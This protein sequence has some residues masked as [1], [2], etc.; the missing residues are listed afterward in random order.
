[1]TDQSTPRREAPSF[2]AES[3]IQ[4]VASSIPGMVSYWDANL[5]CQYAN[6]AYQAWFGK[7]P[8]KIHGIKLQDLQGAELFAKNKPHILQALAGKEQSFERDLIRPNGEVGWFWV[9]YVPHRINDKVVGFAALIFNI[10]ERKLAQEALKASE[11]RRKVATDSGRVAIWEVD[12]KTNRLIWDDNCFLL[13]Q[14]DKEEF[15]GTFEQWAG[16]IHTEDLD[17]VV[18]SFQKTVLGVGKYNPTFR[19]SWPDGTFRHIEAHGEV[20]K[21]KDG[22]PDRFIGTNWDVTDRKRS[23]EAIRLSEASESANLA[24]SIFLANMS[25]ELRTPLAGIMGMVDLALG[26]AM[27]SKQIDWLNKSKQSAL[28]LMSVINDILDI[29]KIEAGNLTLEERNFSVSNV[30]G[31][32]IQ[33]VEDMARGKRLAL[34]LEM[35]PAAPDLLCGDAL[36]LKQIALNY[37]SNAVKF[38]E[39]G[40]VTLRTQLVEQNE[41]S[42]MLRIDVI[43]QGM[44]VSAELQDR[45]FQSFTQ[46]DNSTTRKF[47]GTGLGL[48]ISR[49]IAR[50][51]GGDTG[52]ISHQGQGSTFWAT[53][54]LRCAAEVRQANANLQDFSPKE[55][56]KQ[57]L[58]GHH[59]LLVEDD[60]VNQE[61]GVL[62]LEAVGLVVDVAKNGREAVE[63]AESGSYAAILMDIQMPLMNGLDATRAIRLL[64]D[65]QSTPIVAMSANAFNEDREI[66]L[67]AGMNDHIGKPVL[68]DILYSTL[69]RWMS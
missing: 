60:E 69:L 62:L 38:G 26:R 56:L 34:K 48:F 1:M 35:D 68:P 47:G 44:G 16:S 20:L 15:N 11:E 67:D 22:V 64:P 23:E 3:I 32:A 4:F 54:R 59:V 51:M 12:L 55:L 36:R 61:I 66:S 25:H 57:R 2:G 6:T 33:M 17:A 8:E 50:L 41:N 40:S 31:D 27:D 52:V 28:H 53:V 49:R 21:D 18:Q 14:I 24:K 46:A 29:S 42:V 58:S 9:N 5:R 65:F 37:L 39:R 13:Y 19:I 7:T 45:L 30:L 63:K 10:T 43:D